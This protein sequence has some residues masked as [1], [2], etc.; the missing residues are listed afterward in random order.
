MIGNFIAL[1]FESRHKRGVFHRAC[2][3]HPLLNF[4]TRLMLQYNVAQFDYMVTECDDWKGKEEDKE[5]TLQLDHFYDQSAKSC[6]DRFFMFL[7]QPYFRGYTMAA[8]NGFV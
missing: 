5:V 1:E 2:F 7:K 8:H 4:D 3:S 6:I